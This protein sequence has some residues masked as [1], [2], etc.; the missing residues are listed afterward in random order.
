MTDFY[1]LGYF[2]NWQ[3]LFVCLVDELQNNWLPLK[4]Q[5]LAFIGF[6][7]RWLLKEKWI[8]W[9]KMAHSNKTLNFIG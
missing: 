1:A 2:K 7:M 8:I 4:G 5:Q 9:N 3:L 6:E